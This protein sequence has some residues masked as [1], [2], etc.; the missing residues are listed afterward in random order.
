MEEVPVVLSRRVVVPTKTQ[1]VAPLFKRQTNPTATPCDEAYPPPAVQFFPDLSGNTGFIINPTAPQSVIV[2]PNAVDATLKWDSDIS[3]FVLSN[4]FKGGYFAYNTTKGTYKQRLCDSDWQTSLKPQV[5]LNFRPKVGEIVV[6]T[7]NNTATGLLEHL[8]VLV[9]AESYISQSIVAVI[10]HQSNELCGLVNPSYC[11]PLT[12]ESVPESASVGSRIFLQGQNM[13]AASAIV[14]TSEFGNVV[15]DSI[16]FQAQD[17]L[18]S[19][20]VHAPGG[21]AVPTKRGLMRRSTALQ[22]MN[23]KDTDGAVLATFE[24]TVTDSCGLSCGARQYPNWD[25]SR[26]LDNTQT[27]DD[28]ASIG[29]DE[30]VEAINDGFIKG[31]YIGDLAFLNVAEQYKAKQLQQFSIPRYLVRSAEFK[32]T[33]AVVQESPMRVFLNIDDLLPIDASLIGQVNVT[34]TADIA[35]LTK[36]N[37]TWTL[38][39]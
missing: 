20:I 31:Q 6:L 21:L 15:C 35:H 10:W 29:L 3:Q 8:K 32:L 13:R 28:V 16:E 26:C 19:C 38:D 12:L 23:I 17:E 34:Y 11:E 36:I 5:S 33:F 39:L 9:S 4:Q 30:V 7:W 2:T 18:L 14:I 24:L 22:N 37:G 27:D 25:C 1:S